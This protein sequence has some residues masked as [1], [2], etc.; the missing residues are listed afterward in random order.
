MVL[1]NLNIKNLNFEKK[2][3]K[4]RDFILRKEEVYMITDLPSD[5]RGVVRYCVFLYF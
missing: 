5:I 1:G 3:I 2:I 4:K